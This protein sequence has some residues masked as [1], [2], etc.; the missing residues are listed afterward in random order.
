MIILGKM[1]KYKNFLILSVCY[2]VLFMGF[3]TDADASQSSTNYIIQSNVISNGI[4]EMASTNYSLR[5][6]IGQSTPL[7]DQTDAPYS[8]NYDLYSGFWYT[9]GVD[10]PQAEPLKAMPWIPLLLLGD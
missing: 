9:F 4:G 10:I 7:I 8:I 3:S 5:S 1:L 6:T 2:L